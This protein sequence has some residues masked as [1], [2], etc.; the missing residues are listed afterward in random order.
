MQLYDL[1]VTEQKCITDMSRDTHDWCICKLRTSTLSK[2]SYISTCADLNGY[3]LSARRR[4]SLSVTRLLYIKF[5]R[6]SLHYLSTCLCF[7]LWHVNTSSTCKYVQ[8]AWCVCVSWEPYPQTTLHLKM[9]RIRN[10]QP[11]CKLSSA[12]YGEVCVELR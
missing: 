5:N 11:H 2:Y 6:H 10:R 9:K 3:F 7:L 8:L 4:R 12:S 1:K